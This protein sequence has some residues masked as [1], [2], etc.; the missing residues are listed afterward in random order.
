M[1]ERLS[2]ARVVAAACIVL[3]LLFAVGWLTRRDP[4]ETPYLR[5]LGG[6]FIINYRVADMYYGFTA[7]VQRPLPT[8][9]V[10]VATFQDPA[11]GPDHV[12][13]QRMGGPEMSRFSM[14]SPT[15]HGVEAH[16]PYDVTIRILDREEKITIWTHHMQFSS[17]L[18][19]SFVPDQP[20]T[21]GPG[22]TKNPNAAN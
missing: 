18:D 7:I 8:G 21:I 11:G 14:R 6:G 20:L 17:Q 16:Q 15:V 9:S 5:I 19:G 1:L 3:E 2:V 13:R 22:Y 12:V 10:I 4:D